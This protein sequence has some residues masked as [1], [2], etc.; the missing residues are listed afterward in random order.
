MPGPIVVLVAMDAELVHL[1][2]DLERRTGDLAGRPVYE[3]EVAGA[4]VTAVRIGMGMLNAASATER[5]IGT[6]NPSVILNYGCSGAHRQEIMPGD[7]ILGE[8]VVYH[9]AMSILRDGSERHTGFGF[10]VAGEPMHAADI[11]VDPTWLAAANLAA[12]R[13][14]IDPWPADLAW[15]AD[16]P[17]RSPVIHRG[18]IA[19]ADIWTQHLDRLTALHAR[20][21]SLCEDMEAAAI[22]HVCALHEVPFFTV[23]D[24]SNNEYHAA[25]DLELY[26][27]FPVAEIG[28]RAAALLTA[29]IQD[30]SSR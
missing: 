7:V 8:R 29:T 22:A 11:K 19:S 12:E 9:A 14:E 17:R 4:S 30:H 3:T 16:H 26:S 2:G 1:V 25:S 21:G 27:D 23:K 6:L 20:H 15:P 5:V 28:K 18:A 10:Q 24:I 13:V